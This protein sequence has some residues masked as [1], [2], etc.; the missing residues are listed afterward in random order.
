MTANE[1]PFPPSA[2]R[3]VDLSAASSDDETEVIDPEYSSASLLTSSQSHD[4]QIRKSNKAFAGLARR[5][6]GI[7]L[8]LVTVVL[9]TASSFLASV[10]GECSALFL[11]LVGRT[12]VDNFQFIFADDT[13]SKPYFVTYINTAFFA[14][15]LIPTCLKRLH[16]NH[17][18]ELWKQLAQ[19]WKF[20]RQDE[21]PHVVT[22]EQRSFLKP[23]DD[24]ED[25]PPPRGRS[26]SALLEI[27]DP[28]GT[29][30]ISSHESPE[31]EQEVLNL[32]QT[33]RLSAEFC[34]VWF[35]ANYFAVA[36]LEYTTVA[37]T[38]ILTS[39]SSI[40]TLLFSILARI[41]RFSLPKL[42][43][44]LA[45]LVGI[46][47]ISSVDLSGENDKS[48]GSFPH[49][50]HAQIALGDAMAFFSAIMY[51]VYTVLMKKQI[52]D[53]SRVSMPLF[54]G[55]V[56]LFNVLFLWPG[57]FILHFAGIET[58]QLP[59]TRW[60]WTIIL[61]NSTTSLFS[62]VCW[63][64]AMLLT[65]PIVVTVGLSLTIPLSLIGQMVLESQ[66]S[67]PAYWIGATIVVLSFVIV[68]RES[69]ADG[70]E[71]CHRPLS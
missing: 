41:E 56:G 40:W 70:R 66:Y 45:S 47:L 1:P 28:R 8:L 64:Y 2:I 51:G 3:E 62:D 68:N 6:L 15:T 20:W 48:R 52:G 61:V 24:I 49:K 55:L 35:M 50:S 7:S 21:P 31:A 37:S 25:D 63:A 4:V 33:A 11:T 59:P 23:D 58:F 38:T 54:F 60:V 65:S 46:I 17:R 14:V 53:E 71:E 32:R 39:T 19:G 9:W 5:T 29:S 42:I 36:C 18:D 10:S 16:D 26:P 44:V 34:L 12:D 57:F 69:V 43:G 27:D 67:S 30:Q 22:E 13:Y